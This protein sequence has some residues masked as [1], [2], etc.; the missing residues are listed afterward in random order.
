MPL[1]KTEV[2]VGEASTEVLLVTDTITFATP[3]YEVLQ[4]E[5]KIKVTDCYVC[6][7]KV[8]FNGEAQKNIVYKAPPD[9]YTG[10]GVVV[11]HELT[12]PFAGFVNVPGALPGDQC[13]V[14]SA[15]VKD[16]TVLIP[17]T[18][19]ALGHILTAKQKM[20]A[21]IKIKVVRTEQITIASRDPKFRPLGEE[22]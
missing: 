1:I 7:D 22:E 14:V 16:S 17:I 3:V 19:D 21:E 2:V 9:P 13:Q 11:Y 18:K 15:S 5:V 6:T 12:L 4:E 20:V 8:I 10:E